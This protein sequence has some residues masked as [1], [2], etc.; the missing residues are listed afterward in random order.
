MGLAIKP[1]S[2]IGLKGSL[3][4]GKTTFTRGF[5]RGLGITEPVTSPTYNLIQEY[6]GRI[7]LYHMDLYRIQDEEEFFLLG[8]EE[9][10]YGEGVCLVEWYEMVDSFLPAGRITVEIRIGENQSRRIIIEGWE[11]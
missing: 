2:V 1:G 7:P 3:G 9:L 6:E 10:L 5:A 11:P 4:A 8:A